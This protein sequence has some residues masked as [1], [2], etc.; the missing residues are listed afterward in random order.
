[1]KDPATPL[2]SSRPPTADDLAWCAVLVLDSTGKVVASNES[3]R[4]LWATPDRSLVGAP[5]GGLLLAEGATVDASSP[6][7]PWKTVSTTAL[8]RWALFV[9]KPRS[10]MLRPVRVRVERAVGGAGS[11]IAVAMPT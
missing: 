6:S 7:L 1:M 4:L 11:F 2:P 3:A 5:V 8:N 9:A 10:G